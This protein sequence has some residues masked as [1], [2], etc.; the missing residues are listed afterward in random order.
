MKRSRQ[1]KVH[2]RVIALPGKSGK[3]SHKH[4]HTDTH[5]LK[6]QSQSHTHSPLLCP[7]LRLVQSHMLSAWMNTF[8]STCPPSPLFLCF[9]L[10]PS[11]PYLEW[12]FF[13]PFSSFLFLHL[14]V[15]CLVYK[16]PFVVLTLWPCVP[17]YLHVYSL[18]CGRAFVKQR[19]GD[20]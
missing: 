12:T 16:K 4:T 9:A 18:L 7:A 20:R 14:S 11:S 8:L 5:P 3:P 15:P 2:L 6:S 17:V 19:A 13:F 1:H 10:P